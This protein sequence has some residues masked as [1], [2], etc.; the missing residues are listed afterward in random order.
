MIKDASID[1]DQAWARWKTWAISKLKNI[2]SVFEIA[3]LI[4]INIESKFYC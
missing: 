1:C 2:V 3:K 4:W